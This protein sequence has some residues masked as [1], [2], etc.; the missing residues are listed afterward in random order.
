[1]RAADLFSAR[2]WTW[3]RLGALALQGL[4]AAAVLA[5]AWA[6]VDNALANLARLRI[7][8]GLGFLERP[9]GF[10]IA[11]HLIPYSEASSYGR[12]FVVALVNTLVLAIVAILIA[13]PLGFA[14]GVAR[15]ASNQLVAGVATAYV[16]TLRNLPLLLQLFFW[17]FAVL[18]A[19]PAP[20]RSYSL[21]AA[22]FLNNRGLILPAPAD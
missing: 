10:A 2:F 3:R 4:I 20:S 15:R 1:M 22:V 19:L 12:A 7:N 13:T 8:T 16:E 9:A 18:Q 17:Y 5:V 14:V 6:A 21:G 11:Q